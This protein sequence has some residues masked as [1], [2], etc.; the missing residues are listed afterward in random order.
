MVS[1][2]R[3]MSNDEQ[4]HDTFG[5][6]YDEQKELL[7]KGL[8]NFMHIDSRQNIKTGKRLLYAKKY[9]E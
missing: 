1:M 5:D 4:E 2:N 8:T 9:N 3:D 7:L 6:K